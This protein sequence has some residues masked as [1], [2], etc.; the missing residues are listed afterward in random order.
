VRERAF[1]RCEYCGLLQS[2]APLAR[3]HIEHIVA[4]QHGG[5]DDADNLAYACFHCN[6]HK[7]PNLAGIDPETGELTALFNPRLETWSEH[8]SSW[9]SSIVGLTPSGRVTV[10][11]LAMNSEEMRHLR[12]ALA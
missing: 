8:F 11:V 12:S 6:L 7:G 5:S 3:F 4:R 2:Q 1:E 9:G 10:L